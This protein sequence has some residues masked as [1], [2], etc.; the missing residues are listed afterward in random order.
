ML[1]SNLFEPETI[2]SVETS[3]RRGFGLTMGADNC[4]ATSIDPEKFKR[5]FGRATQGSTLTFAFKGKGEWVFHTNDNKQEN[6][7]ATVIDNKVV[8]A[9]ISEETVAK[10]LA[11][12][13][14]HCSASEAG[15]SNV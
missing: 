10:F 14:H 1:A 13:D 15:G 7:K 9:V 6:L 8:I 11:F 5:A 3:F 2:L 12:A 4:V